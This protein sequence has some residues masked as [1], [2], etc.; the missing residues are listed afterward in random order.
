VTGTD[1]IMEPVATSL[2]GSPGGAI[3]RGTT[4]ERNLFNDP[5]A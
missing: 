1:R 3:A 4:T 5:Y 2:G